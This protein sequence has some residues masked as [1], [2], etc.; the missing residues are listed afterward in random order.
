MAKK[1][2]GKV[3]QL[4]DKALQEVMKDPGI[5]RVIIAALNKGNHIEFHESKDGIKVYE[6]SKKLVA[7]KTKQ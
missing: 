1:V 2:R 7:I 3:T 5:S 4:N 6:V